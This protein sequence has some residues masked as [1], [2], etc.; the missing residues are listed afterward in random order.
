MY[1]YNRR[2][3]GPH[4]LGRVGQTDSHVCRPGEGP[5]A[6]LPDPEGKGPHPLVYRGVT[7]KRSRN[8]SVGDAQILLNR[9]LKQLQAGEFQCKPGADMGRIQQIRGSLT[10]DP[11]AVDCRFGP[12]TEKAT[13]MFQ[14]CTLLKKREGKIG[15][16]TRGE[17]D[18]LRTL[19]PQPPPPPPQDT[20]EKRIERC[21]RLLDQRGMPAGAEQTRRMRCVM[22]K[23]ISIS[24][25][26]DMYVN[27]FSGTFLKGKDGNVFF[28]HLCPPPGIAEAVFGD[29]KK[30][31]VT[32]KAQFFEKVSRILRRS[33]FS[34]Q[35]PDGLV[36]DG[37]DKID[38]SILLAINC[39]HSHIERNGEASDRWRV[40]LND[41]IAKRQKEA[42]SIYSC[43]R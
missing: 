35:A 33:P 30:L 24:S 36:I 31:S 27:G 29:P 7:L 10:Q 8:P 19:P 23:R 38:R 43:Y 1:I 15:P 4:Q 28:A 18:K 9:F 14:H 32:Q 6:V 20:L 2:W 42:N 16:E 22:N 11:L 26:E 12:N 3:S 40:Q 39:L 5:P 25:D 37:L 17:L 34:P 13:R 41:F 21:K